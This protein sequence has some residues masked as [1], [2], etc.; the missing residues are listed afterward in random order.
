MP[1]F[2]YKNHVG[3]D[4]EHGFV[5]RYSVTHAAAHDGGQLAAVLDPD[6][7]ASEVWADTAYRSAVNLALLD[8][9]C[10]RRRENASALQIGD[11]GRKFVAASAVDGAILA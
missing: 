11:R 2:G 3:I 6:N 7:T 10:Q 1:V 8:R 9:R 4:R 5:R